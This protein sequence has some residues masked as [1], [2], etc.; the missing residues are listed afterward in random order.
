M[1]YII[2]LAILIVIILYFRE[3]KKDTFVNEPSIYPFDPPIKTPQSNYLNIA[4][5]LDNQ[6]KYKYDLSIGLSP[7]PTIQCDKLT[8]KSNCNNNGCNW[9]G[10]FCSAIYPTYL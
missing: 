10:T 7:I 4:K 9:F 6:D 3:I 5:K 8:T 2:I 1:F